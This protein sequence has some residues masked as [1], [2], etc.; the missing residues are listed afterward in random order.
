MVSYAQNLEDAVLNRVFR[1][2]NKG[3][4]IDV[5]AHHPLHDS[6]TKYFYNLSNTFRI[7]DI[8][9]NCAVSDY[10]GQTTFYEV[11]GTG[12]S[13]LFKPVVNDFYDFLGTRVKE[14]EVKVRTLT[15]I[16]NEFQPPTIDFKN[17][18]VTYQEEWKELDEKMKREGYIF[19]ISTSHGLVSRMIQPNPDP[20]RWRKIFFRQS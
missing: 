7:E 9:V 2:I 19:T 20:P 3:F 12:L 5:G 11:P 18:E 8:N 1:E 16:L 14:F 15:D 13:S 4:Y 6:V 17:N 10:T